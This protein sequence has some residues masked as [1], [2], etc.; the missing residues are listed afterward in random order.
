MNGSQCERAELRDI[1][2]TALMQIKNQKEVQPYLIQFVSSLGD[3]T[4]LYPMLDSYEDK[5][6]AKA[7]AE[8]AP[9]LKSLVLEHDQEVI[10]QVAIGVL[11]KQFEK[12]ATNTAD[13]EREKK[14][15]LF[16]KTVSEIAHRVQQ[17]QRPGDEFIH[18]V[19]IRLLRQ[20]VPDTATASSTATAPE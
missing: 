18:L 10:R 16:A 3:P 1:A 5:E 8:V 17:L 15:R 12:A 9:I 19:C 20:W 4:V 14:L 13:D 6:E 2:L 11:G 7:N